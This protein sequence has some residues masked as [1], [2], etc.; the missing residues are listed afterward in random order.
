MRFTAMDLVLIGPLFLVYLFIIWQRI[1]RLAKY[2]QLEVYSPKRY[3][4]WF[5]HKRKE[6]IFSTINFISVGL[7]IWLAATVLF[8]EQDSSGMTPFFYLFVSVFLNWI[9]VIISS[10]FLPRDMESKSTISH[11]TSRTRRLLLLTIILAMLLSQS[12]FFLVFREPAYSMEAEIL[13]ILYYWISF[14]LAL[15]LLIIPFTLPIA[16]LIIYPVEK[17][18]RTITTEH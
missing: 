11:V 14:G 7:L 15:M 6:I 1:Q 3:L 8:G 2:F 12:I 16:N 9:I 13:I 17:L 4:W 18:I 5:I 10:I